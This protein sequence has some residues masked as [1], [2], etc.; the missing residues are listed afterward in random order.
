MNARRIAVVGTSVFCGVLFLA[1]TARSAGFALIEQ[2]AS[3]MGN[4]FAGAAAVA[5]DASTV[6]FNP[7]G[8]SR[9][10]RFELVAGAS[11]IGLSAKFSGT[12]TAPA[13]MGGGTNS[14][15][16]G[17][18]A[19]GVSAVPALYLVAP[20]G[21]GFTAGIGVSVPF[22]LKT[23]Y[24]ATWVGRYQGILSDVKTINVN[25]AIAYEVNDR[26]SVGVG[27]NYQRIDAELTN[28]VVL[29]AGLEGRTRLAADDDSWGW[30][31][32]VLFRPLDATRIG[33]SYR[34]GIR[35]NLVGDVTTTTA[36]G[37]VVSAAS[38]G[39]SAGI[40]LPA[41]TSVSLVQGLSTD[42]DLLVDISYTNWSSIG[43]V[44]VLNTTN[45][46]VRD[47]L[48]FDFRNSWRY[49]VGANYR[50]GDRWV[51]RAG[52]A[53]DQ[54]P[55][56]GADSRTV[57]LPDADRTWVALGARWHLSE[58]GSLD[59]AYAHLFLADADV[60]FTRGQLVTGTTTVNPAT[61][62]TVTG[63]YTGSVDLLS[64]QYVQRF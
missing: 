44:T 7:A 10:K 23:E 28:A 14:G 58:T 4:A 1:G 53:F 59:I 6:F 41:T 13:A 63:T 22:G 43:E 25:P 55:V 24:D 48:S 3:G 31:A 42:L 8:M 29:G 5:E 39:A 38:G 36:A 51:L 12:A 62:T 50:L 34:S 9:L 56:K 21:G 16:D 57:R 33:V 20:V 52:L 45:G 18:D 27:I 11:A 35:H 54:T 40:K 32:G 37:T 17:G 46:T 49:S 60:N 19:G 47:I 26:V 15:G 64:V 2:G 30:N 61:T